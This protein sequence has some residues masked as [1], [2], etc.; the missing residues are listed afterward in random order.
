MKAE[1]E[2]DSKL[3]LRSKIACVRGSTNV[4]NGIPISFKV[5]PMVPLV[6]MV[7]RVG[8]SKPPPVLTSGFNRL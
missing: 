2:K 5:L 6:P 8:R 1:I 7:I 3:I 4:T